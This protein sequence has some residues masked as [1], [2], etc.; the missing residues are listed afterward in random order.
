MVASLHSRQQAI[1]DPS[2]QGCLSWKERRDFLKTTGMIRPDRAGSS[3]PSRDGRPPRRRRTRG[4]T[5]RSRNVSRVQLMRI[6]VSTRT[7]Q[8]SRETV[9]DALHARR[10]ALSG[11]SPSISALKL[12]SLPTSSPMRSK[13]TTPFRTGRRLVGRRR[14]RRRQRRQRLAGPHRPHRQV[15]RAAQ[16][17]HRRRLGRGPHHRPVGGRQRQPDAMPGRKARAAIVE[18][19]PHAVALPGHQRRGRGVAVAMGE[20]QHA[21]AHA[22]RR[23]VGMRRRTAAR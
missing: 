4:P 2:S 19:Q 7:R 5:P 20:V 17:R 21:E 16:D 12:P 10:V 1:A 15:E 22:Q 9:M 6:E 18:L 11:S 13:R 23:A 3:G 8:P 14:F